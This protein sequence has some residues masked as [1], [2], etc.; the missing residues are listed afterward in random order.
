MARLPVPVLFLGLMILA[1]C[2]SGTSDPVGKG[3]P[4]AAAPRL[5]ASGHRAASMRAGIASL[6]DNGELLRY[7]VVRRIEPSGA[8]TYYPISLSEAHAYNALSGGE[9]V[10]GMPDGERIRLRK[11]RHEEY[12]DGNWTL[13]AGDRAGGRSLLT[14]GQDAVFG[15]ITR[16][17]GSAIRVTTL[18]RQVYLVAVDPAQLA[19]TENTRGPGRDDMLLPPPRT[20]AAGASLAASSL[21]AAAQAA[22]DAGIASVNDVDVLLGF[23]N[24]LM[25]RIGSEAGAVTRMQNIVAITNEAYVNSGVTMRLRLVRSMMVNFTDNTSN[26]DA[27]HKLTGSSGGSSVPIDP[28]FTALRAARE[29]S[30]A[31]LVSLVRQFRDPENDGCGIAWLLGGGQSAITQ[32]NAAFAYSVVSDG[33]DVSDNRTYFCRDETLAHEIGHNLGQAHNQADSS[34][35]GAHAYSYGYRETSATGFY[36]IM[37]YRL[38]DSGQT[39]IRYFANPAVSVSGRPTGVANQSD[40]VRSMNQTMPIVGGFRA[41]VVSDA[42]LDLNVVL[43]T[44]GSNRT[45]LFTMGG[46]NNFATFTRGV[47]TGLFGTGSDRNWVFDMGRFDADGA[48]DLYAI[49]KQGANNKTEVFVMNGANNFSGFLYGGATALGAAGS[50]P[51]WIFRLGDYNGDGRLD[52]YAIQRQGASNRT[53]IHV[54]NGAGNFQSFLANIATVLPTTGTDYRWNFELGDWNRDGVLDLFCIYKTGASGR[55]EVHIVNGANGFQG[56]LLNRATVLYATGVDNVW[57]FKVGDYNRDRIPD[58]YAINK[59]SS[60]N[61]TDVFVMNGGDQFQTYLTSSV[62]ALYATGPGE[63]WDF[64]LSGNK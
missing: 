55:T 43:K 46:S 40:N 14:F 45:E 36:T 4:Q 15:S 35:A 1:G 10:I 52:L 22:A 34:S 48:V 8:Y 51:R 16:A 28:A 59:Q 17:D 60:G 50:D 62:T 7:D 47:A 49:N 30:G 32:A 57:E 21:P 58:V 31:D 42:V 23:T 27:L 44:G 53:E 26:E 24:G 33:S 63:N 13:V 41:S 56:Y 9:L 37:A 19:H 64:M 25:A 6:P 18:H 61:R 5:A 3:Q 12:P 11:E 2:S 39:G 29:E 20:A 38:T 54:L